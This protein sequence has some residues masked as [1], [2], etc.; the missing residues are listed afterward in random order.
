MPMSRGSARSLLLF[1]SLAAGCLLGALPALAAAGPDS[2]PEPRPLVV[3]RVEVR[4]LTSRVNGVEYELRVSLPHGYESS[5]ERF[6]VVFTLDADYSFLIARNVTDH[7]AERD[8]LREV[9]VV[10][11][12][13]GGPL[14]Y[15][16]N[17]TRDYTPT[18]VP[19]GGYGA[20]F[21]K[22]S[23]GG[24]KFLTALETEIIPFVDRHYRTTAA[25]RT[26][27]GHSYG[28]LFTLWSLFTRP[29]LFHNYVAVSPSLWYDDQLILRLEQA[30]AREH[31]ALPAR[32]YLCVGSREGNGRIDMVG[33][34]RRLV[35]RLEQRRYPGLAF[36]S[37]VME[38]ETHNSIFP[39]CLSNGLRYVLRGR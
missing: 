35:E 19:E 29:G 6:P 7:L 5:D 15:R 20:E 21:Q 31:D 12:A 2:S 10:G 38:D 33:D 25:D 11:V 28:G 8:H 3:E 17:R 13:Y 1:L 22:V 39:G 34:F 16:R 9:I 30:Y 18:F 26:L 36:Q 23:G 37:R 24:P 14:A 27:V 4:N 32:G